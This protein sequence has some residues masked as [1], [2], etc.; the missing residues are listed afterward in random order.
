[1]TNTDGYLWKNRVVT[2]LKN[3]DTGFRTREDS[4]PE[5]NHEFEDFLNDWQVEQGYAY[6]LTH[7]GVPT[8][9]YQ[10]FFDWGDDLRNKI[11]ALINARKVAGVHAGST[12]YTQY[13][14]MRKRVYAARIVGR[15]GDLYVRIG[16]SD[17]D[18][19]PFYSN[20]RD[21]REY[22]Q[23]SGWKVWVRLNGNPPVRQAALKEPLPVPRY[24]AP[25]TIEVI[26]SML[27]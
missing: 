20:Y 25:D 17:V 15:Y 16:G 26:D 5:E 18:W 22:A 9:F 3:H 23:G 1:M 7:P 2:F 24:Q 10:H 12:I 11:T 8:V 19:Q 4:S 21:Y 14:A 13:N 27:E 6:I